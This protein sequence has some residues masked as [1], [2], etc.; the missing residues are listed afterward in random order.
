MHKKK[1]DLP[2]FPF[3]VGDWRKATDVQALPLEARAVWFEMLCYMWESTERGYLTVN[4][5]PICE[6]AL[7][8]MIGLPD[9]LL[10]QYLKQILDFGCASLRE[11]DGAIYSRRMVRD[12]ELRV[13]R[14]KAGSIGGKKRVALDLLKQN[15]SNTSSVTSSKH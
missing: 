11:K 12:Q 6:T 7:A 3:Y 15:S 14:Q 13:K 5:N 10:K 2:Y 8:R 4:G 1:D 9:V